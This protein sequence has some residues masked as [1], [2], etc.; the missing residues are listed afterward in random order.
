MAAQKLAS[1][2]QQLRKVVDPL[3]ATLRKETVSGYEQM[4]AANKQYVVSDSA[5]A[6]KLA[7]QWFYTKMSQIPGGIAASEAE[8]GVLKGKLRSWKEL[9]AQVCTGLAER[10]AETGAADRIDR[11]SLLIAD[12][13]L[14]TVHCSL[15]IDRCAWRSRARST[16]DGDAVGIWG[17][18]VCVVLHR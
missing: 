5:A 16:G 14:L 17:R 10:R 11:S 12:C 3:Y 15:L 4:M 9:S 18:A 13:P 1:V 8:L 7:K 2:A 6:D